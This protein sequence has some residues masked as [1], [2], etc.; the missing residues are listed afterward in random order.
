MKSK[1]GEGF[2]TAGFSQADTKN[3]KNLAAKSQRMKTLR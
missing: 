3:Y 1:I 2:A